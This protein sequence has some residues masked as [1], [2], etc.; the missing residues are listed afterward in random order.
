MIIPARVICRSKLNHRIIMVIFLGCKSF[1]NLL[2]KYKAPI[3]TIGSPI[4]AHM[5]AISNK[6]IGVGNMK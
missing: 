2:I 6:V 5:P 1:S 3:L 4:A